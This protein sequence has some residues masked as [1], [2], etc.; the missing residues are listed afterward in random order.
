MNNRPKISIITVCYNAEKDIEKTIL[1]VINQTYDKVE[2]IV[3]DGGSCDKTM[4]IINRYAYKIDKIVSEPDNGIYDAMNKGIKLASGKWLNFMNAGDTFVN[5]LV[6]D[7]VVSCIDD[8][9]IITGIAVTPKYNWMPFAKGDLSLFKLYHYGISH[10]ASF[11]KRA[12]FEKMLFDDK[13]KI[14]SDCKFF[15]YQL[16]FN[17]V[18]YNPIYVKICYFDNS[19]ISSNHENAYKELDEIFEEF[20]PKEALIDYKYFGRLSNPFIIKMLPIFNSRVMNVIRNFLRKI[21]YCCR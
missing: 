3:V 7:E 11:I 13:Y 17:H 15:L 5:N 20:L 16:I 9:D 8:D 18:T 21:K 12:L 10:Q 1:S 14:A 19:G 2:Y 6:I 4:T